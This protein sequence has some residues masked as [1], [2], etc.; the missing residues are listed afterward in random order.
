MRHPTPDLTRNVYV[1]ATLTDLSAAVDL[2]PRTNR[3]ASSEKQRAQNIPDGGISKDTLKWA[4]ANVNTLQNTSSYAAFM[5]FAGDDDTAGKETKHPVFTRCFGY[6]EMVNGAGL[7]PA[8]TGLKVRKKILKTP[9]NTAVFKQP[10]TLPCTKL[11]KTVPNEYD[12]N[13]NPH[14]NI[15]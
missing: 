6:K 13:F 1:H 10:C 3:Q 7:E 11:R 8:A 14:L 12:Y 4:L 2:L 15:F 9:M 5:D